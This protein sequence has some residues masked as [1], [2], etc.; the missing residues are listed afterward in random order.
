MATVIVGVSALLASACGIP[1]GEPEALSTEGRE[2]LLLGTS[3][4]TTTSPV[5]EVDGDLVTQSLFFISSDDKLEVVERTYIENPEINDVLE[6]LEEAPRPEDQEAFADLDLT[7]RSVVPVGL[8]AT[9]LELTPENE[10]RGVRVLRVS[11]EGEL[12]EELLANPPLARLI[13]SQLV[14]TFF[15][16]VSDETIGV[17]IED[18]QGRLQPTDLDSQ[19]IEA[20]ILPENF[21]DCR[22]GSDERDAIV[23][24]AEE[25]EGD[26]NDEGD[27]AGDAGD[28]ADDA[29]SPTTRTTADDGTLNATTSSSGT[30]T[31]NP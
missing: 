31:S 12:R 6:E 15:G 1:V 18:D 28:G 9:L 13:V 27:D 5:D 29:G 30:T 14:C 20:P 10:E 16:L 2:D 4:T 17:I 26:G 23:E 25:G 7:L 8:D 24:E 19:T 21:G 11:P 22:T 3:T